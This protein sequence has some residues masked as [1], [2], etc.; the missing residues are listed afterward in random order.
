MEIMSKNSVLRVG[1]SAKNDLKFLPERAT[2]LLSL[3]GS[4]HP[5]IRKDKEDCKLKIIMKMTNKLYC[6]LV[7][8]KCRV[9]NE[10]L[11][12]E[13]KIVAKQEQ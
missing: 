11:L 8:L 5:A 7:Y 3:S 2:H 9:T 1:C 10:S 4:F 13:R 12:P 6:V